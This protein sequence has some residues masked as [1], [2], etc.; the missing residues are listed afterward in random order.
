MNN[1]RLSI[2]FP[3]NTEGKKMDISEYSQFEEVLC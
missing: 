2:N 3:L 1:S